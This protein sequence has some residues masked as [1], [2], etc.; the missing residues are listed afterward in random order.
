MRK[1]IIAFF[2]IMLSAQASAQFGGSFAIGGLSMDGMGSSFSGP[3]A[4]DGKNDCLT[5][6]NG[7][8]VLLSIE[9]KGGTFKMICK[10]MPSPNT[11]AVSVFPN[12]ASSY[13]MLQSAAFAASSQPVEVQLL[14]VHGMVVHRQQ[15]RG[16]Q[17]KSGLQLPVSQLSGGLYMLRLTS[18]QTTQT[19]KIIKTG[20]L[21]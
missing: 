6:Q 21:K 10:D 8:S 13:T 7:V 5:L 3:L 16:E 18:G 20:T 4:F 1:S 19:F 12:P 9:N 11:A 14:D 15:I 2:L 17:L